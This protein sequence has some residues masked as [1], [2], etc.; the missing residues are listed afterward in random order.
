V[1]GEKASYLEPL[2]SLWEGAEGIAWLA[3]AP[4]ETLDSGNAE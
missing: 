4:A 2:R 1:Y 3:V